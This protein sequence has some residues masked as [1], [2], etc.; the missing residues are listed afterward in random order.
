MSSHTNHSQYCILLAEHIEFESDIDS[1]VFLKVTRKRSRSK[2]KKTVFKAQ[3]SFQMADANKTVHFNNEFCIRMKI[4][5]KSNK[6]TFSKQIITLKLGQMN[7]KKKKRENIG[8]WRFDAANMD[9]PTS[10]NIRTSLTKLK[11]F[12][13]AKLYFRCVLVH[14][15]EYPNGPPNNFFHF[16]TNKIAAPQVI[17]I[18]DNT[19]TMTMTDNLSDGE[20]QAPLNVVKIMPSKS[21]EISLGQPTSNLSSFMKSN[22]RRKRTS[23]NL[24][25]DD[26]PSSDGGEPKKKP[27]K[28]NLKD[29]FKG[30]RKNKNDD[31][32]EKDDSKKDSSEKKVK[33][34]H[35]AA[36]DLLTVNKE[37]SIEKQCLDEFNK[38]FN[39]HQKAILDLAVNQC[40]PSFVQAVINC[41]I[42][43]SN[44][45]QDFSNTLLDPI[46]AFDILKFP[47]LTPEVL[48]YL[49]E[50]LYEGIQF[51]IS[52][53]HKIDETFAVL[54][55]V[56]NFGLKLSST[57]SLYT[58]A[59][60]QCLR[61][62]QPYITQLMQQLTQTL[63]ATIAT[64][65]SSDG[66]DFG[67]DESVA[68]I[69]QQTRMFLELVHAFQIPE[70]IV[71]V[72]VIESCNYFD[73]LLFNVII[74]TADS[75]T[76]EKITIL[77]KK[78]RN[79]QK[80]FECLPSNFSTAF[81]NL[82]NFISQTKTLF[83]GM[84]GDKRIE[85]TP[86]MRSIIE[87][88]NPPIQLPE[89]TSLDDIGE[90]VE[91]STLK[92]PLQTN[93]FTFTFEWLYTQN[94]SSTWDKFE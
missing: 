27:P 86:L 69:E 15:D 36:A 14:C 57:S 46:F 66:F 83:A 26:I 65:I 73:T 64:S 88:C 41:L 3:T 82:L 1:P 20:D 94:A 50:P 29:F 79:I 33:F 77:L 60:I 47:T 85:K 44:I 30:G 59:H 17:D 35:K 74:D 11:G 87:R 6:S 48:E 7:A 31:E 92:I 84:S 45:V 62:L 40:L 23:S 13:K 39:Q 63:V 18:N 54:S 49:L 72:I 90:K 55:T 28:P 78:I 19:T 32:K 80:M 8:V 58:S 38:L 52:Q 16:V 43:P 9:D 81:T 22:R 70:Q 37:D 42:T 67:D 56:L 91:T 4:V 93:N 25:S 76:D 53:P 61:K 51:A 68:S 2:I 5:K 24:S 12:G 34:D 75:F 21:A 10:V 89:G 71:Q